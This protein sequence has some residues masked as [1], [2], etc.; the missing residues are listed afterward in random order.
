ANSLFPCSSY[1]E[2]QHF[3]VCYKLL[4]ILLFP[5]F[6][7]TSFSKILFTLKSQKADGFF[8]RWMNAIAQIVCFLF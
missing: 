1:E 7:S 3:L 2:H 4:I 8:G 6:S 5:L